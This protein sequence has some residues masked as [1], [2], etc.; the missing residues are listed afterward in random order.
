MQTV[1]YDI[2]NLLKRVKERSFLIPQ[3]QRSFIW[4]DSQ[5][6]LLIDSIA[7]NYPIGSLLVM[8]RSPELSLQA[9]PVEAIIQEDTLDEAEISDE[10]HKETEVPNVGEE[11]YVLDGQQ[12]LTSIAR[13]FLNAHPKQTYYFNLKKMVENFSTEKHSWIT[14]RRKDVRIERQEK[15]YLRSDVVLDQA[16]TD[17]LVT[18]Y[19]EDSGDFPD[20]DKKKL[21]ETAARIKG[22]FEIM[23]RFKVPIVILDRDTGIES[24]CRVFETINSTGTRLTTFDLAVA[25]FFP[26]PDLRDRLEQTFRRY[27]ILEEF[28]V[29]GERLLQVI[30]IVR[31]YKD[32]RN[33]EPSRGELLNLPKNYLENYWE[34]ASYH[35]S[36]AYEWAR[37]NG[38]RPETVPNHGI[39]VA[40]ASFRLL[41][42]NKRLP[43]G[44]EVMLRQWYFCYVLE[45]GARRAT[46]YNIGQAFINLMRYDSEDV[47]FPRVKLS[48]TKI[49]Q[50]KPTDVRYKAIQNIIAFRLRQDL[51]TGEI[52]D[53]HTMLHDHHIFP[54]SNAKRHEVSRSLLDSISNKLLIT[55][56]SNLKLGDKP[57]Q[58]YMGELRDM[59][60]RSGTM[61]DFKKRL[62]DAVIPGDP[63]NPDWLEQFSLDNL[64][65]F[66][67][68]RSK[69]LLERIKA[70][71]GS[72]LD[73][74]PSDIVDYDD[75][76]EQDD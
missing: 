53:S 27:P 18:E 52:I 74:D 35:L 20:Y 57:T 69:L 40:I 38:A 44:F 30:S 61:G 13:V 5:T 68:M 71:V 60:I 24:V 66:L 9:R 54:K 28:G 49:M 3:F 2:K 65:T 72:H 1:D 17:I 10:S 64:Q 59:A 15:R 76:D 67:D 34:S 41:T 47:Q 23:R 56:N 48:A 31:A 50:L 36:K 46:N 37:Q 63:D 70:I 8:A 33:V 25:R 7:R 58:I 21:R 6:R 19:I 26:E 45:Q 32:K 12:R 62:E 73:T 14:S 4:S 75:D 39:L 22:I 55:S 42:E 43:E 51:V 16:K 11:L 29:E